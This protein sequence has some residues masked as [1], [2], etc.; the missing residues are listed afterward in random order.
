MSFWGVVV[1]AGAATRYGS[2]KQTAQLSDA[3]LWQWAQRA[4]MAGG[5]AGVVL[6][7]DVPN[8]VPGG[9]R[10]R[11]SVANGLADV[12][13]DVEFILVHDAARPLAS[14][15]LVR[16]IAIRLQQG[17]ADGVVPV[18]P[19][20]DTVKRVSGERV[21]ETVDRSEL[22]MVQTPQGFTAEALRKAHASVEGD[23]PDDAYL[24]E[25]AGG[26]VVSVPG[27]VSNLKITFPKDLVVA[28]GLLR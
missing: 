27:E 14:E 12:P 5:A 19:I 1:A 22:V 13:A 15:A 26:K 3:P 21:I 10:R 23:A 4:L 2:P 20:R 8:G 25:R 6:V 16:S 24:V 7:G 18:V 9:E 17:D 28:E 11:D